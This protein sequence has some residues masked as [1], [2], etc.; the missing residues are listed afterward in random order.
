MKIGR[1]RSLA[2]A[3]LAVVAHPGAAAELLGDGTPVAHRTSAFAGGT[4]RLALRGEAGTL[5]PDARLH[6]GFAHQR[7]VGGSAAAE[8]AVTGLS[9]GAGRKGKAAMFL[10]GVEAR[11]MNERLGVSTG[12][13]IAI[14]A[15]ATLLALIAIAAAA[16]P[17]DIGCALADDPDDC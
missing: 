2:A 11:D 8:L 16:G 17:P 15:G 3:M 5:K 10:G 7:G 13:A 6:L 1:M 12:G 9:F 4:V 14:G